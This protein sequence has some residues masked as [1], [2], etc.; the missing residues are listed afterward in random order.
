MKCAIFPKGN[1]NNAHVISIHEIKEKITK[2][3]SMRNDFSDALVR[4]QNLA[5]SHQAFVFV[6]AVLWQDSQ[7]PKND[8]TESELTESK[9]SRQDES[10][11]SNVNESQGV[12]FPCRTDIIARFGIELCFAVESIIQAFN[13]WIA[14][15]QSVWKEIL[16]ILKEC[17]SSNI[18][19]IQFF[20]VPLFEREGIT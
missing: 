5:P 2:L 19:V 7:T 1:V 12:S 9:I 20:F 8:T 15:A 18:Q 14:E 4:G 11:H 16:N 3:V 10:D 6:V 13:S 17:P